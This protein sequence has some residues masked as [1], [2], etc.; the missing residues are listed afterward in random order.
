MHYMEFPGGL[1]LHHA[2]IEQ[3]VGLAA[4]WVRQTQI[5]QSRMDLLLLRVARLKD[6]SAEE[7]DTLRFSLEAYL[8]DRV[9]VDVVIDPDLGPEDWR[10]FG[11]S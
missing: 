4:P 11:R 9:T 8:H 6:P 1:T 2:K 5:A 3:A 7:I 10:N